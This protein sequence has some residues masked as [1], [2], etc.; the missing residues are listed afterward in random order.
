[1]CKYGLHGAYNRWVAVCQM[2]GFVC[3]GQCVRHLSFLVHAMAACIA[4]RQDRAHS[5]RSTSAWPSSLRYPSAP[6]LRIVFSSIIRYQHDFTHKLL[7]VRKSLRHL[8]FRVILS[9]LI[10]YFAIRSGMYVVLQRAVGDSRHTIGLL[11]KQRA[12][13]DSP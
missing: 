1:M 12:E 11:S 2:S 10:V 5:L 7:D 6:F 8:L 9:S 13:I 4:G 3:Q